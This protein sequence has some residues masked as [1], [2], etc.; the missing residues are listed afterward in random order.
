MTIPGLDRWREIL[1]VLWRRKLRTLLTALSVAWG[2]FMLV[3][4]LGAGNGL[5]NGAEA[6]FSRDATN[7]VFVNAGR[8]SK[9]FAGQPIGKQ[10]HFHMDDYDLM[11]DQVSLA[12]RKSARWEGSGTLTVT[13]GAHS[14]SYP[15]KGVHPDHEDIEKTIVFEGR[16]INDQDLQERRKVAVVGVK[17]RDTLF[18]PGE[19]AIGQ[20]IR[21][22]NAWFEVVGLFREED[23]ESEEQ[24]VYIPI[25][26]SHLVYDA[27][28]NV[29]RLMF[30]AG[31]A[32]A[33][34]TETSIE[35]LRRQLAGR[36]HFNPEDKRAVFVW[37]NQEMSERFNGLFRGIRHF[38]WIIGLGTILAG[39]VGVSN[40]MLI[41]VQER[42]REIGVRKA[43]GAPPASIVLMIVEEALAITLVSGYTGLVAGV[44][45][46]TLAQK[47]LPPTPFFKRPDVDI[48]V[49]LGATLVLTVAGVV[50]GLFPALRAARINPIAALRV[51]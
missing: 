7:A 28:A 29:H 2:I 5:S 48:G 31:V 38:I 35:E 47:V 33:D 39:V 17:V 8:L 42:T 45:L 25:T 43:V 14:A 50:A 51:E 10:V 27:A 20:S 37:N 32:S 34:Q 11:R 9:P 23:E 40:I 13:R 22:G 36:H 15:V 19:Q 3:I 24:T 30:T 41:S 26:T 46:L 1:E 16:Y 18:A 49:A 21:L 6:E 4:L 44:G 12:D